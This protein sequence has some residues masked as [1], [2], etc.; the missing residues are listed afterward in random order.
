MLPPMVQ[1]PICGAKHSA[2]QSAHSTK[3]A[4]RRRV[5]GHKGSPPEM[6]K[7]RLPEAVDSFGAAVARAVPIE[8]AQ[9]RRAPLAQRLAEAGDFGDREGGQG[10][11]DFLD[12]GAAGGV[13]CTRDER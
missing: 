3:A 6:R 13:A 8:E 7:S 1:Q 11:E 9:A 10:A 5:W 4:P 12:D 2:G